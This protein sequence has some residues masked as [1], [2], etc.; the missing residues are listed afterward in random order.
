MTFPAVKS[1][2]VCEDVRF[3]RDNKLSI[4]G[5][6]GFAP[7]VDIRVE[8]GTG[9][10]LA[11]VLDI[12]RTDITQADIGGAILNPGRAKFLLLPSQPVKLN[13][14]HKRSFLSINIL[15]VKFTEAGIH[16]LI[17]EANGEEVY[18]ADFNVVA[19]SVKP[20]PDVA[21]LTAPPIT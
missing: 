3:E 6:H 14:N 13:P 20:L 15:V 17:L 18:R 4:L 5:V 9:V 19:K 8:L 12:S 16:T 1:C 7:E 21:A 10:P 2:I 11:F